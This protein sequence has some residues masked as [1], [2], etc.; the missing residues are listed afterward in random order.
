MRVKT[1]Q[2]KSFADQFIHVPD[3]ELDSLDDLINWSELS[4]HLRAIE[5]DYSSISLLKVLLLQTWFTLSDASVA[6]ALCRDVVFM[7]FCEFSLEGNKP[8]ASTICR[9]RN[10][11]VGSGLLEELLS[12]INKQ[13]SVQGLKLSNGKYVSC[14]ATL[15]SSARR[16]RKHLEGE[17]TD[18]AC[19]EAQNIEYSDDSEASW[20]NKGSQSVYGYAGFVSTDEHGLVEAVSTRTARDS[21]VRHFAEVIEK[22]KLSHGKTLLYDKGADSAANREALKRLGLRDGIMRK[23]PKGKPMTHWNWLRNKLIS[24]RRFVTERTFGTL[25]RTYGM[26]RARYLGMEKVNAELLLKSISY[27]LKRAKGFAERRERILRESYA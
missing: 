17:Q 13:L 20:K 27:N 26:S 1:D 14:D 15:I 5:G 18:D 8:N 23:K 3:T 6:N 16:P 19:Y 12:L 25:K 7:R 21:E 10:R 2:S 22:S 24:R 9:F 4:R 11:L